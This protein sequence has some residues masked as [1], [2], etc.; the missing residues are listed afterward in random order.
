[1]P[2]GGA[3]T[4]AAVEEDVAAGMAHPAGLRP[5]RYVRLAATDTGTGMDAATLGRAVE[6]FFT[7][8]PKGR[9]TGLGLSMAKGFAEQSGGGLAIASTPGR[10]ATVSLWLPVPEGAGGAPDRRAGEGTGG[11]GLARRVLLVDDER[12]VRETLAAELEDAGCAVLAAGDGAQA[13]ALLER[14]EAVDA[15]VSDLSMPGMSGT[16]LIDEAQRRRPGLPAV[17]LTG[18]ADDTARLE[19]NRAFLLLRKPASGQQLAGHVET[20]LARSPPP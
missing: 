14:G 20:L 18:Y 17:L 2:E 9:G 1:M 4:L 19:G 16:T 10:G 11:V 7:T 12:L 8:K 5:G 13:L 6:P 15:L 3:L